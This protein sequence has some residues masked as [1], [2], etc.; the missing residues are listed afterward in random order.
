MKYKRGKTNM[1]KTIGIVVMIAMMTLAFVSAGTIEGLQYK[2]QYS[3]VGHEKTR[4]V[5]DYDVTIDA[6]TV[7]GVDVVAELELNNAKDNQQDRRLNNQKK[8][9]NKNAKEIDSV[10]LL[11]DQSASSWA[12]DGK[13]ISSEY[14][15][16]YLYSEFSS[17]LNKNYCTKSELDSA[18][19]YIYR[20]EGMIYALQ[21]R[22]FELEKR[23]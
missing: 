12:R 11:I 15:E 17:Y 6:D 7:Q 8:A 22:V 19:E 16:R 10:Q 9:I 1:K 14:M 23:K 2:D 3:I 4:T 21:K 13:G 5:N 18:Y 20:L